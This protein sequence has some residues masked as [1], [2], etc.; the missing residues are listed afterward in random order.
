FTASALFGS[1]RGVVP[2]GLR[3]R[4][5]RRR[6]ARE[7]LLRGVYELAEH[8]AERPTSATLAQLEG[9][10]SWSAAELS[11]AITDAASRELVRREPSDRVTLTSRGS[12][13][14]ERLTRQ[15]RLWELYLITHAEVAPSRVDRGADAIEHVLDPD[16]IAELESLLV[17]ERPTPLESP[18]R[19]GLKPGGGAG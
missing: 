5:L 3:R 1:A 11:R 7:H 6:V 13:E 10:R 17:D 18:H 15:H 12:R 4:R 2:R 16:T 9:R 14:A 19:L 8:A